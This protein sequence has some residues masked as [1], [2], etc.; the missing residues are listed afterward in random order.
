MSYM[1]LLKQNVYTNIVSFYRFVD[2]VF[3]GV[4][5]N[6]LS[7]FNSVCSLF[8]VIYHFQDFHPFNLLIL[9]FSIKSILASILNL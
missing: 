3:Q 7:F 4:R 5:D 8:S 9:T 2:N 1:L 6:I